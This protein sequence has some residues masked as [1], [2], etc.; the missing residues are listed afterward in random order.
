[1]RRLEKCFHEL[2]KNKRCKCP[3]YVSSQEATLYNC[4]SLEELYKEGG[5]ISIFPDISTALT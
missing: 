4:M 2:V 5:P 3:S 1:M